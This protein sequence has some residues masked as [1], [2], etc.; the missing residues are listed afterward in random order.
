MSFK[1]LDIITKERITHRKKLVCLKS[2]VAGIPGGF[3]MFGTIPADVLQYHYHLLILSQELAY[4][5]GFPEFYDEKG[6]ATEETVQALVVMFFGIQQTLESAGRESVEE[7]IKMLAKG[8]PQRIA[9]I[10]WGNTALFKGI[11]QIAK[12]L[13]INGGKL[14]GKKQIGQAVG[15]AIPILGGFVSAGLSAFTFNRDAKR[16]EDFLKSHK[17]IFIEADKTRD[18]EP[19]EVVL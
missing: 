8:A 12:W 11:Q 13:G 9:T 7:L 17:S 3:A 19:S 5:Y 10:K 4:L 2:F 16:Y 18:S 15:K 1:T 14:V 6:H